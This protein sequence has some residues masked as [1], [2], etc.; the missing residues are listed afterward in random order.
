MA[1]SQILAGNAV[2]EYAAGCV[3]G[4]ERIDGKDLWLWISGSSN[5]VYYKTNTRMQNKL[6]KP[7]T[8][9]KTN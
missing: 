3:E 4:S 2:E 7:A 1:Q 6:T 8:N 9:Y 5:D